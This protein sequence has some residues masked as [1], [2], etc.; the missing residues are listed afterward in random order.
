MIDEPVAV[1]LLLKVPQLVLFL[2]TKSEELVR[3]RSPLRL[4]R[5]EAVAEVEFVLQ[6]PETV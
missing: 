4:Y 5:T 6:E 2:L 1:T 3:S